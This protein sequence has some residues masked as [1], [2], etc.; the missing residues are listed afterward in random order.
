L[1]P[2]LKFA[3]NWKNFRNFICI[4][5]IRDFSIIPH[6]PL[7]KLSNFFYKRIVNFDVFSFAFEPSKGE[8]ALKNP[9]FSGKINKFYSLFEKLNYYFIA[10]GTTSVI[11]NLI[12]S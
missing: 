1:A 4:L 3:E 12:Q 6:L 8:Q 2:N 5:C 11:F 7:S 10:A 9:T